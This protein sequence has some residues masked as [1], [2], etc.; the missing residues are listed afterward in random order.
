[1]L[2][3]LPAAERKL[4]IYLREIVLTC[5]PN[6]RE[7]LSY[8]VP[9]YYRHS[10]ICYIWPSSIPWGGVQPNA[11]FLGFCYGH[12]LHDPFHYLERGNRKQVLGKTF[13]T[14]GAIDTALVQAYLTQAAEI[15]AQR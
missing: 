2:E 10:R 5:L 4:T 11:V 8:Q 9:F 12:L 7:K 14:I 13:T 1:L 15:D 6:A 3:Y